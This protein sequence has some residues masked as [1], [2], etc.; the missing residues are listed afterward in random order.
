MPR[1]LSITPYG[2]PFTVNLPTSCPTYV[3]HTHSTR[4]HIDPHRTAPARDGERRV[5]RRE[6][7]GGSRPLD[8]SDRRRPRATA[9]R[10]P[11]S[12]ART[13][14]VPC[15]RTADTFAVPVG[16]QAA[17][18][19]RSLLVRSSIGSSASRGRARRAGGPAA[20]APGLPPGPDGRHVESSSTHAEV[21]S[22]PQ[23]IAPVRTA[24]APAR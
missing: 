11:T 14:P 9:S 24:R 3:C 16:Q 22:R 21:E 20:G 5:R 12:R 15:D 10:A 6:T 2:T 8:R 19:R 23:I 1:H 17:A 7:R 18:R 13:A 4:P